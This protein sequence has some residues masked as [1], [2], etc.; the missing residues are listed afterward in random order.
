M[1]SNCN[2]K[3]KDFAEQFREVAEDFLQF[4]A[5]EFPDCDCGFEEEIQENVLGLLDVEKPKVMVYGIYNSGKSTLINTLCGEEVA[6]VADRPMTDRISE[7]DRGDYT[8]VDSPGVDAPIE[9]ERV[10]EQFLNKCHM[11]LFVISTKGIFEDRDNYRRLAELIRKGIPFI[12]VLNDR[13]GTVSPEWTQEQKKKAKEEHGQELK[14][15]QYK[16]IQ[17]LIKVSGDRNI[18]DRYEVVILNAKK[19]LNGI[20]KNNL[21]LYEFSNVAFLDKRITQILQN[22][23]SVTALFKQ[24]ASNLHQ[25]MNE[26][27]QLIMQNM[28]GNMTEDFSM[29]MQTLASRRNN[30][31]QELR[32]MTRQAVY[33]HLEELSNS[34]AGGDPEVFESVADMAFMEVQDLFESKASELKAFARRN[35]P[36]EWLDVEL[37][38]YLDFDASSM[39]TRG[40]PGGGDDDMEDYE[41]P[42]SSFDTEPEQKSFFIFEMFKSRK[43]REEEKY[44]RLQQ[45]AELENERIRYQVQERI[46]KKQ[47]ARQYASSDLDE[48]YR[49]LNTAVTGGLNEMYHQLLAQIQ[50]LDAENKQKQEEGQRQR[51]EL[52]MLRKRLMK[53]ENEL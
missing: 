26:A 35:F 28:N 31:M 14:V 51:E 47:E 37:V 52:H 15:I 33:S 1:K 32:I 12:I 45:E 18:A 8:L 24:P 4:T 11:I 22:E 34:Y 17:N 49:T 13:G 23:E 43:R 53:I 9:H 19:A 46:R 42:D 2:N 3:K 41:I 5:C 6:P 50:E 10:T 20:Q 39:R 30:I 25:C 38:P 48:L 21:K 7:Y 36:S 27:E 44:A 29:R 16:V 40:M